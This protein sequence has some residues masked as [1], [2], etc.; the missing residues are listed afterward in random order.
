LFNIIHWQEIILPMKSEQMAVQS[1][2]SP[3]HDAMALLK[4]KFVLSTKDIKWKRLHTRDNDAGMP[5]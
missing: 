3:R 1:P 2:K 4:S 5:T